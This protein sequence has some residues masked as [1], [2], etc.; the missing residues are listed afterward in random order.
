MKLVENGEVYLDGTLNKKDK[1]KIILEYFEKIQDW[2]EKTGI[3]AVS[4]LNNFIEGGL[5]AYHKEKNFIGRLDIDMEQALGTK[6]IKVRRVL[7]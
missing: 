1:L 4:F 6:N 3:S 7:K 2:E 5:W